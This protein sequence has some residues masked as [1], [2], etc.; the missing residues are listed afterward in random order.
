VLPKGHTGRN[1]RRRKGKSHL[2]NIIGNN[3][4]DLLKMLVT[5]HTLEKLKIPE[6]LG[7]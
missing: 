7:E 4:Q 5:G 3:N 6:T 2:G 1:L